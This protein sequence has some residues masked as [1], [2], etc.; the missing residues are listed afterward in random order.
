MTVEHEP[1]TIPLEIIDEQI[2]REEIDFQF[3]V[4]DAILFLLY[5]DRKP[6]KGK[7]KQQKEVFLALETILNEL[8]VQKIEFRKHRFGPFSEEVDDTID[9][10]VFANYI[11]I[12]GK[13]SSN[14]FSIRISPI[15]MNYIKDKFNSLP[16]KVQNELKQ[17]RERW[18][19]HTTEGILNVVYTHFPEYLENSVL[20]N[21]YEPLDWSDDNQVKTKHDN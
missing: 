3:T 14:Q 18:D 20:K 17:N 11:E 16:L 21:R 6:I 9:Q 2:Q 12:S 5:A 10:L 7:T 4:D 8:P 13:K 1:E 19:T 15:G